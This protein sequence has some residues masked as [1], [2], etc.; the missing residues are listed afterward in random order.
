MEGCHTILH[1]AA[2]PLPQESAGEVL[3]AAGTPGLQDKGHK[4][5]SYMR[6]VRLDARR[7]RQW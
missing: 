7:E 2:V 3:L 4:P 6:G 1:A 5:L